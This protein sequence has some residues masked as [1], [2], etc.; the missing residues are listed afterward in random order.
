[1]FLFFQKSNLS[2]IVGP[3]HTFLN[4]SRDRYDFS[5]RNFSNNTIHELENLK[6]Q[7]RSRFKRHLSLCRLNKYDPLKTQIFQW[8]MLNF[9][10]FQRCFA[11]TCIIIFC[12][13]Y[14]WNISES[15]VCWYCPAWCLIVNQKIWSSI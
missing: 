13:Q 14:I 11:A 7:M 15:V 6:T 10:S 12:C 1:M 2:E 8:R 4:T 9:W 3:V 5:W